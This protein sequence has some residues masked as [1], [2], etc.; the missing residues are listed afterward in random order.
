MVV[1]ANEK[2]QFSGFGKM[3]NDVQL[4]TKCSQVF[5]KDFSNNT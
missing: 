3:K 2:K 1:M 4:Y 5:E